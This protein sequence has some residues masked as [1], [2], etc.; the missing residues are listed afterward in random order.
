VG[1]AEFDL[2]MMLVRVNIL[3]VRWLTVAATSSSLVT[4]TVAIDAGPAYV[5][6]LDGGV[7]VMVAPC[8][9]LGKR[10]SCNVCRVAMVSR[11]WRKSFCCH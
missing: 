7:G 6:H 4:L 3:R 5:L 1:V 11:R 10:L 8:D 2:C 9:S